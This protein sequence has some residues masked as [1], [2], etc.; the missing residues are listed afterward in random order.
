MEEEAMSAESVV[1][2]MLQK[3]LD[4]GRPP[5][6]AYEHV[7]GILDEGVTELRQQAIALEE[8]LRAAKETEDYIKYRLEGYAVQ[9][10]LQI[11]LLVT[12]RQLRA[13]KWKM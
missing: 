1:K 3:R 10:D 13:D 12:A 5:T 8:K 9:I 11:G 4:E 7:I 6:Q 2:G